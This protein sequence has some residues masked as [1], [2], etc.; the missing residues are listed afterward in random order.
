MDFELA[1]RLKWGGIPTPPAAL[2]FL[3]TAD[4]AHIERIRDQGI[5]AWLKPEVFSHLASILRWAQTAR[6]T[7]AELCH[8]WVLAFPQAEHRPILHP[9]LPVLDA[10][11][12]IMISQDTVQAAREVDGATRILTMNRVVTGRYRLGF[13][14]KQLGGLP[15]LRLD[16]S[17]LIAEAFVWRWPATLWGLA[18]ARNGGMPRRRAPE[19]QCTAIIQGTESS[20][21][22]WTFKSRF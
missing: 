22:R 19:V 17:V 11:R 6:G 2:V 12:R 8:D 1:A 20:S 13:L 4:A 7:P 5:K 16:K 9:R 15:F 14:L 18:I 21:K 3:S 10:G